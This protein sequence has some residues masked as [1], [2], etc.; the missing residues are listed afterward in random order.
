EV[1]VMSNF[2]ARQLLLNS[3]EETVPFYIEKNKYVLPV[4]LG[5][6]KSGK[7]P[8]PITNSLEVKIS[9]E[10]ISEV[11]FDVLISDRDV[12]LENHSVTL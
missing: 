9:L 2:I 5:I 1:D 12:K 3:D 4:V 11:V 8:L 6:M 10:R 7:I